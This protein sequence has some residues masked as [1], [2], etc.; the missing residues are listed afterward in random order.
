MSL[1]LLYELNALEVSHRPSRSAPES[2]LETLLVVGTMYHDS[3][4]FPHRLASPRP[5]TLPHH[6]R[7]P[8]DEDSRF[9]FQE[10]LGKFTPKALGYSFQQYDYQ[11][12]P[13]TSLSS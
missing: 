12:F 13:P 7:D 6:R 2:Q 4:T 11:W 9:Q 8:T 5:Q 10:P 1:G 3:P